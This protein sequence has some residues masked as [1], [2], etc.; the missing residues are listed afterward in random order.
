MRDIGIDVVFN[1]RSAPVLEQLRDAAP[2]G[3]DVYFDNVGADHLDA[4][5]VILNDHGRVA[6]SGA[7]ASYNAA[8]TVV[9][10]LQNAPQAFID[11]LRGAN[12]GK[13]LVRL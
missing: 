2:D 9:D 11:L 3:L 7:I 10:G 6:M 5:L 12:T 4:A 1:Y 8:E 13:M